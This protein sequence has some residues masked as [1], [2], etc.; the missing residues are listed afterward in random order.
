MD[1][2][3]S[4]V[5]GQEDP[6]FMTSTTSRGAREVALITIM[7]V[8]M[9]RITGIV[10]M[11]MIIAE[12]EARLDGMGDDANIPT[13]APEAG[14]II[15]PTMRIMMIKI[16]GRNIWN[17]TMGEVR[18]TTIIIQTEDDIPGGQV[19]IIRF[20]SGVG[21]ANLGGVF[22]GVLGLEFLIYPFA[23]TLAIS[24]VC[25]KEYEVIWYISS[26]MKV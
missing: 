19:Q 9:M 17:M 26:A 7:I 12:I 10:I 15:E 21:I 16:R 11:K 25:L 4:R 8:D 23:R 18:L 2:R 22:L 14:R 3:L 13:T 1:H 6:D 5:T 20:K 24:S